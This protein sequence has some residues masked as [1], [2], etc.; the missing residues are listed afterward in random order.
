MQL[1]LPLHAYPPVAPKPRRGEGGPKPRTDVG[2]VFIRHRWARRYILRVMD[3]GTLR[4][5]LPR[6]GSKRDALAFVQ[7]S[8]AWIEQQRQAKLARPAVVHPDE[9]ALRARAR[10]E[11]PDALR[12]LAAQHEVTVTR[13]S[14]R[15]QRSRWGA[16]SAQGAITLNWRLVLVP[17]FVRDYVMLH[18]LMHC[19]ELNHSRRF[20]RHV[21][22]VCPRY[23]EARRWLL[24]EG[25]Q[26]F[27]GRE[28]L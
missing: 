5:T 11:L 3:D 12:A 25:Q 26:L 2:G 22:A 19:R 16:C 20:W 4:V 27:V 28:H 15:N 13:V 24:T 18:E 23:Q 10:V 21:A 14:V 6:W 1:D 8:T 17:A 7:A 9:P